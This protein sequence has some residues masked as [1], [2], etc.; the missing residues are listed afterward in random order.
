MG[1]LRPKRSATTAST[2]NRT[3]RIFA[4]H[5]ALAAIPPKPNNVILEYKDQ[6]T[7]A[8]NVRVQRNF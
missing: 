3:N 2:R 5:A 8:L 1:A 7:V 4:N 6:D